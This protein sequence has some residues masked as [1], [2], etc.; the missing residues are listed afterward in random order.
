MKDYQKNAG[1]KTLQSSR[2][3]LG[4]TKAEKILLYTPVLKWYLNHGLKVTGIYKYLKYKSSRP[5]SWFPEDVSSARRTGDSDPALTQLGDTYK[6]KGNS[7]YGKMIEDLIKHIKTTFTGK[8]DLVDKS[9]RSPFF[10]NLEQINGAFEIKERKRK[11]NITRPCQCGIAVYQ[12]AKLRMLEIYY[13]FPDKYIDRRD[14]ELIQMD[15]DSMYMALLS[16]STDNII[17]PELREEYDNGG[18]AEFLS[19][20]KYHDRTP[21]LFKAEFQGT[22]MIALTSKCYYAEDEKMKSKISCKGVSKKQNEMTWNRYFETLSGSL[23]KAINT[24]F[25]ISRNGVVTYTHEKLGLSTYYDKRVVAPDGIHTK[26]L[27]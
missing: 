13:D 20:S 16:K 26:L 9:F 14:F 18:K 1:R 22:R 6:L 10:E 23:D 2:K 17:R 8:E 15:T 19:T 4:V 12:L 7:F 21:G 25:R 5:F 27:R 24:G 11:V 3:V